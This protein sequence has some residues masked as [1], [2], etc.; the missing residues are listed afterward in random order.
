MYPDILAGAVTAAA[1]VALGRWLATDP[2][3]PLRS[4]LERALRQLAGA[5]GQ[6]ESQPVTTA[7]RG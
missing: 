4:L 7:G 1:Q 2:P 5:C 6:M 3:V